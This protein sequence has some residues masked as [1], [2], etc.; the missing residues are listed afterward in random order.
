MT[1][2]DVQQKHRPAR[3]PEQVVHFA[4]F[5]RLV[6]EQACR[7]LASEKDVVVDHFRPNNPVLLKAYT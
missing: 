2:L 3:L 6:V 1:G 7:S 4:S 5:L